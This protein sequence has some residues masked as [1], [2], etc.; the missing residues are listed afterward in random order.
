MS[1]APWLPLKTYPVTLV[2]SSTKHDYFAVADEQSMTE[3]VSML[4]ADCDPGVEWKKV[5]HEDAEKERILRGCA[6]GSERRRKHL[7]A[8]YAAQ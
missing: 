6:L 8:Y 3:L 1:F 4:R 2:T 7:E 5:T